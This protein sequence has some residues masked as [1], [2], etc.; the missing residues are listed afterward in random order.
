MELRSAQRVLWRMKVLPETAQ[1]HPSGLPR[2][3][4]ARPRRHEAL[5]K[6]DASSEL[7]YRGLLGEAAWQALPAPTRARF[8]SHAAVYEGT[9]QLRASVAG[10]LLAWLLTLVGSP[11]PKLRDANV[12]TT[13]IVAPDAATGGSRWTRVYR[14]GAKTQTIASVKAVEGRGLVERLAAG[15]RMPLALFVRHGALHFK[16]L[17]YH[18]DLGPVRIALPAWWPPGETEVIH[19]DLG[20]GRFRFTMRIRHTWLGELVRHDGVFAPRGDAS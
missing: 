4:A 3:A 14:L 9:M 18:L 15:V 12:P 16:S 17:G 1:A 6:P 19:R 10:W 5:S 7:D 2:A 11:L 13:V 20:D 8:S